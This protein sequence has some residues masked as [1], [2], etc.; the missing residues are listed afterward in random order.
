MGL[1][2][3]AVQGLYACT[4]FWEWTSLVM[5]MQSLQVTCRLLCGIAATS[6]H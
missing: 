2:N 3:T 4:G 6:M 1:M 5:L